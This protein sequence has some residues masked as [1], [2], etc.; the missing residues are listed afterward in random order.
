MTINLTLEWF[1]IRIRSH[2]IRIISSHLINS[3][4]SMSVII[5]T[6]GQ[7]MKRIEDCCARYVKPERWVDMTVVDLQLQNVGVQFDHGQL[8]TLQSLYM[9]RF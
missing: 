8:A 5:G 7:R 9:V 3:I 6:E 2:F 1:N 4:D